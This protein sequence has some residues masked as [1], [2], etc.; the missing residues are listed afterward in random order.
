MDKAS[1]LIV[2]DELIVATDIHRCLKNMGY[3]V[4]GQASTGSEA[5]ALAAET[6]PD[7]V[8]IDICL[9]GPMDGIKTAELIRQQWGYPVIYLT[10]YA[11]E[12]TL[13]RA[14][15]TQPYSYLL[16]PFDNRDLRVAI[17][18]TLNRHQV[19]KERRESQRWLAATLNGIGDAVIATDAYGRVKFMNPLAETLT[20]WPEAEVTGKNADQVFK[21]IDDQTLQ[22]VESPVVRVL[23]LD[24]RLKLGANTLLVTRDGQKIA[25]ESNAAPIKDEQG[26]TEGVVLVFRDITA[27][28]QTEKKLREYAQELQAQNT[29]LEAFAHTAAHDLKSPL[30]SLAGFA[31]LLYQ[32]ELE[33]SPGV[34]DE[35][36]RIARIA[37]KMNNIV[38][39]LLLLAQ[40]RKMKARVKEVNMAAIV[41]EAQLRLADQID[42]TGAEIITPEEWPAVLGYGP[43]IEEVWVN[44]LSNGLKYG[45][46]PPRLELGVTIQGD[47]TICFWVQDNGPGLSS[48]EQAGLFVPFTRFSQVQ[49][50]GHGLGLSIVQRI[51]EKLGGGVGVQSPG[52]SGGTRFYF[53]LP[54]GRVTLPQASF[55][56]TAQ[57][58]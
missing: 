30:S 43:W 1:I 33:S 6:R 49:T 57:V 26:Q 29:D 36:R 9:K 27:R 52:G 10:A 40:V 58:T 23:G 17:E 35:I 51:I 39:E 12:A 47:G 3:H 14:K 5:L 11:D 46:R 45:G 25:I 24:H 55:F 42:E 7:L 37:R 19:E 4:A 54:A 28:K 53:T 21:L 50:S 16:K 48:E 34:R 15:V 31:E 38:D 44:Y 8:L 20:G 18:I 13:Q 22:R 32:S 41:A 56:Q 2:E